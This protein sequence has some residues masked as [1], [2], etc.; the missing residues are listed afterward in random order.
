MLDD[1]TDELSYADLGR[2]DH[3]ME[4]PQAK[5]ESHHSTQ[6]YKLLRLRKEGEIPPLPLDAK[7][8]AV[9]TDHPTRNDSHRMRLSRLIE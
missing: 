1:V 3:R 4:T 5:V 2:M 7:A 8:A 6:P 9:H